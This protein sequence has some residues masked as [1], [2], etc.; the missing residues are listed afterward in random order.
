MARAIRRQWERNAV[1]AVL[2]A[3]IF[4]APLVIHVLARILR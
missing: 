4:A 3:G 2:L 1:E